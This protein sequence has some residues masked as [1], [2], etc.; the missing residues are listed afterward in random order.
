MELNQN[1]RRH[2]DQASTENS[3]MQITLGIVLEM[4]VRK[5][6][7]MDR[8]LKKD[9]QLNGMPTN[10]QSVPKNINIIHGTLSF[11]YLTSNFAV[12]FKGMERRIS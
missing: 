7:G 9:V 4:N 2:D 5:D 11:I 1:E 3:K 12:V 6:E 8:F 10:K